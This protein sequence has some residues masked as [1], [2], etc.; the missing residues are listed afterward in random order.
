MEERLRGSRA[1]DNTVIVP[2]RPTRRGRRSKHFRF[3]VICRRERDDQFEISIRKDQLY[4]RLSG[5]RVTRS[6]LLI[7]SVTELDLVH[8][9]SHDQTATERDFL[10]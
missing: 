2:F 7:T 1:S 10:V 6:E 8:Q 9:R 4:S 3:Y 5:D